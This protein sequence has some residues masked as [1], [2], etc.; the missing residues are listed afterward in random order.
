MN[1][2][3]IPVEEQVQP[4]SQEHHEEEVAR[5]PAAPPAE[6]GSPNRYEPARPTMPPPSIPYRQ[7]PYYWP[8]YAPGTGQQWR[9]GGQFAAPY[10]RKHSRWPWIVLSLVLLFLLITGGAFFLVSSLGYNFGGSVTETQHFSVSANPTLIVNNDTGTIQVRAG[11]SGNE[12]SI[13][14]TRHNGLWGNINDI[15]VNYAQDTGSNTV[16]VNVNRQTDTSFFNSSSVDFAIT[17]PGTAVLQ[18]KTNTG[19]VDVNGVSGQMVLT[20]N[21]GSVQASGGTLS[22]NSSLITNTGSITFN[23]SIGESGTYQFQTNTGSVNVTLPGGSVFHVDASTDTGSINTTFPGVTVQHHQF[24][25]ADAHSD[26]GNTPQATITLR[27]NTGTI[28]LY[29]G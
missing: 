6:A 14:A 1:D 18:L 11:G 2:Q 24:V 28:N 26:V 27:T 13:Q 19:N 20:S 4:S 5:K 8:P 7:A 29:Q 21:T 17:V 25:G 12:V 9:S 23:G 15:H 3:E 10:E 16:M 22:G